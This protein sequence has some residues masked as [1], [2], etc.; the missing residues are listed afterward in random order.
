MIARAEVLHLMTHQR[1]CRCMLQFVASIVFITPVKAMMPLG[2][3]RLV[4]QRTSQSRFECTK[5]DAKFSYS[6]RINVYSFGETNPSLS[7]RRGLHPS[8]KSSTM[9]IQ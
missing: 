9:N 1:R 6:E 7:W 5:Y 2:M 8:P 3:L 4:R